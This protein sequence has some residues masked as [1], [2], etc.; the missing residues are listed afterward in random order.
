MPYSA[1]EYWEQL[2]RRGDLSAV[3]QSALPASINAWLYRTLARNLGTFLR[4]HRLDRPIP[5]R[6]L[7]VGAGTGYWI[8]FWRS[9][10]T[11]RVDGCDLVPEAVERLRARFGSDGGRFF[12][13]DI[14][15]PGA[16]GVER[17]DLVSC[18]NV[19]LHVTDDELF[20]QALAN[21]ASLVAP[22]G[23]LLLTEPILQRPEFA[24][25]HNPEQ[26][27]R[28]RPLDAYR[29]PLEAAGLR[30]DA[31]EPATVIANNPIEAGSP[32]SMRRLQAW[33]KFVARRSKQDPRSAWWLG[34]VLYYLDPLAL[35]S[36]AAPSSKFAL[37][38]R[39]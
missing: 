18:M 19:L 14:S 21:V 10:G 26:H 8:A 38:R 22:G 32:T 28:A 33:W 4:R 36:G 27:S 25:P 37:F 16:L 2:H 15:D 12:A 13:A 6:V 35:R 29:V 1:P 39:P 24:R 7:D 17:Y 9:R 11:P 23:A 5:A 3:G 30:L 20:G 31:L 34:R